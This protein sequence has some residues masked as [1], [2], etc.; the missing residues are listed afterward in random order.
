M[1]LKSLQRTRWTRSLVF[2]VWQWDARQKFNRISAYLKNGDR[3]LEVG[4]GPCSVCLHLRERGYDV[5]PLDVR[6]LSLTPAVRPILYDGRTMP[7]GDGAFDIALLL[8]V[9]HHTSDPPSVLLEAGRVARRI[10]VIED[11]YSNRAQQILTYFMDS[12]V[13]LEFSGHPHNNM[14]DNEWRALFA[15]LGLK[16]KAAHTWRYLLLFRQVCHVLQSAR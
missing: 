13:N 14:A 10:I 8:T 6:D 15:A 2:K 11:V 5:T 7:F 9:L 4:C 16:L 12:L 1:S 3:V